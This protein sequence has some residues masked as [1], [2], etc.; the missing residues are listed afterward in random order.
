VED[1]ATKLQILH[2]ETTT[3]PEE[4][5]KIIRSVFMKGK[6]NCR[7]L[8]LE[9]KMHNSSSICI[10]NLRDIINKLKKLILYIW[11]K[12]GWSIQPKIVLALKSAHVSLSKSFSI[13]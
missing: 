5:L 10:W 11:H 1:F 7:L 2:E 4:S 6:K 3:S 12:H 13:K 8:K 9:S